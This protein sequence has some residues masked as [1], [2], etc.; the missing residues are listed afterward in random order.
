MLQNIA[1]SLPSL[2]GAG[3]ST[4]ASQIVLLITNAGAPYAGVSVTGNTGGAVVAYDN[5]SGVYSDTNTATRSAG[6]I[7]LFNSALTGTQVITL[8]DSNM[9]SA[10]P[11]V[12]ASQGAVTLAAVAWN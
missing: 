2:S 7:I 9:K 8:T 11:V 5:G 3:V 12:L 1:S 6:I 4:V 10:Q